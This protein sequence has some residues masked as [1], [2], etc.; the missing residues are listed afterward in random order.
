MLR[1]VTR[2]CRIT[3]KARGKL[4]KGGLTSGY[5]GYGESCHIGPEL[6]FGHVMGDFFEQPVL[7][8]Q[9]GLGR[10]E[11]LQGLQTTKFVG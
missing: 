2:S 1:I 9:D 5:T 10:Q 8:R 4:R 7:A 6:Q 3:F 11:P